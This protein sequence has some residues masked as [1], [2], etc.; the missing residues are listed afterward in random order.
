MAFV[1]GQDVTKVSLEVSHIECLAHYIE[2]S[3]LLQRD[4]EAIRLF[5]RRSW[6]I[7]DRIKYRMDCR[8]ENKCCLF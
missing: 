2:V 8:R 6:P 1:C 5:Q 3:A 7:I 4:F